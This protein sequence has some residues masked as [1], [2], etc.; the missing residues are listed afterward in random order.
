MGELIANKINEH[1]KEVEN[2]QLLQVI[3]RHLDGFDGKLAEP[4]RFFCREGCLQKV[5]P[6]G[7]IQTR[8]FILL[9]DMLIWSKSKNGTSIKKN[10]FQYKG[11][12]RLDLAVVRDANDKKLHKFQII[13]LDNKKI[14]NLV[15]S[16]E[17][18]KKSWMKDIDE[19]I[20]MWLDAEKAKEKVKEER[21]V[22]VTTSQSLSSLPSTTKIPA[23]SSPRIQR[24]TQGVARNSPPIS[25]TPLVAGLLEQNQTLET[26]VLARLEKLEAAMNSLATD[27]EN[28]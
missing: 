14:Y 23:K 20:T 22:Y 7:K 26:T 27:N 18:E 1:K 28:L 15:A 24:R 8:H 9:S 16:T 11:L 25:T 13:K 4:G 17:E 2:L 10:H 3:Q 5:N 19:L 12:I 6:R 21:R